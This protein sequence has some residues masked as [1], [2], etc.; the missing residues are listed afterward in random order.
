MIDSLR[1]YLEVLR[2]KDL[3]PHF[4]EKA[5]LLQ[6]IEIVPQRIDHQ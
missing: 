1:D 6:H 4:E 2:E 3:L 5:F